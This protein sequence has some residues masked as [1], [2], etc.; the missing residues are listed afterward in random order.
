MDSVVIDRTVAQQ[1]QATVA[2]APITIGAGMRV[3]ISSFGAWMLGVG[4]VIGS[5]AWLMHGPML[6][7][8]GPLACMAAWVIAGVLVL[9]MTLILME[10]SSMFP[11]AGGP[12]V[13]KYYALKRLIPGTGEL[14]GFLTGWLFWVSLIVGLACM[15]NGLANLVATVFWGSVSASP[16]WSGW[17]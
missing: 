17:P 8:S 3:G 10:L 7:R 16:L 2:G 4:S 15:A 1:T 6:A 12:Y 14:L 5:M 11:S 13:Y 9:P